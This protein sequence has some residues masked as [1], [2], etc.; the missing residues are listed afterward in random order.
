MGYKVD[1]A[2]ILAAGASSRFAP[3]SY[4]RPK[5]LINV[6]G[7]ILIERQIQQL[8]EVDIP[9]I[10]LVTGY[11]KEQFSYLQDK[12]GVK[13]VENPEYLHRNNHSSI[14]RAKEFLNNTYIC[15][16]D[17]Y[18]TENPFECEVEDCYY[19]A[20]YA[21]GETDEWCMEEDSKGFISDVHIGGKD[22]WYMLGHAFWNETFSKD[23]LEIL[24]Q[25]YEQPKT[26]EL[27]WEA[28]FKEN[29]HKLKMKIRRYPNHM[30]YE[31][32]TLDEL[33]KFDKS[34]IAD[35]RS[36]ILKSLAQRLKCGEER[37]WEVRAYKG[38]D[39]EAAGFRFRV[40][41]DEYEYRYADEA[42]YRRQSLNTEH[43]Q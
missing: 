36:Q 11:K 14:Y 15:S 5:A 32:D 28:I 16:S 41:A 8:K 20:V 33:R 1:N 21:D 23:F 30:I 40:D 19:S 37:I 3:L 38:M 25:I 13:L 35:T 17:N 18:F 24:E 39:N 10:I 4:E 26:K 12:F 34:Y 42:L 7:E 27:L 6:K 43:L 29:L 9:E 22:S 31:F 2:V